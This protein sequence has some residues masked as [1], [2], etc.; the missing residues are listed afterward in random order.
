MTG[1]PNPGMR[2]FIPVISRAWPARRFPSRARSRTPG[3]TDRWP[4]SWSRWP[5]IP[6]W[7]TDVAAGR[8]ISATTDARGRYRLEGLPLG[9]ALFG[10]IPP[11]GSR[12]LMAGVDVKTR[13]QQPP[14]VADIALAPGVMIRG[15][16]TDS[17]TGMPAPGGLQY[18]A[19]WTN[20]HLQEAPGFVISGFL[21]A[22]SICNYHC[23]ADGRF[24]IPVLPGAG[25]LAF[26]ADDP[27]EFPTGVGAAGIDGPRKQNGTE[28]S[29]AP[30]DCQVEFFH[31][32]TPLN[33]QPGTDSLCST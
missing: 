27:S 31:L 21:L 16:A 24:E 28:F 6:S 30:Y 22:G 29:T 14:F 25:I 10:V 26:R 11:P 3:H 23:D 2:Q 9:M 13:M 8:L 12:Y 19:L 4:A 7:H 18:F 1:T 32:L 5:G 15:R 20:P 17:R 33:P